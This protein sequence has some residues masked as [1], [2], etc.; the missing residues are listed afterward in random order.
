[1]NRKHTVMLAAL[2]ATFGVHAAVPPDEARLLGTSLTAAGA[3][4]AANKDGTIPEYTGGLTS[5]PAGFTKG[6]GMRPD[7]YA[8]DKPRL[9]ITGKNLAGMDDKLTAGTRELLKRY[10]SF[11]VDVYPS[12]RPVALPKLVLENTAK[13]ALNARTV[14]GGVG[15]ENALAGIPFPIPTT[16]FEVMWNHLLR[17]QGHAFTTKYESW[18]VDA[19]GTPSLATAGEIYEEFPLADP[20]NTAVAK[21]NDVFFRTKLTYSAPARRAGEGLMAFDAVNP[22][23]QPRKVWQYL[24]GQRRVKLAPDVAYDT[25]N[26]GSAGSSTYD[27]AWIFNEDRGGVE[28]LL[29]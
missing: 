14:D 16:G 8:A 3:E 4:K 24:P 15:V 19:S 26:P 6:S 28:A 23:V 9:V 10:A 18:N 7:P 2:L 20:S 29:H 12:H 21:Q 13:N 27:N 25:P 1:M 22:A 17:Y 5:A 11:R